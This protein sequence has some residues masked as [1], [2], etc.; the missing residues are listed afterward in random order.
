MNS[1]EY[2]EVAVR[3]DPFSE[4]LS[5]RVTAEVAELPYESFVTEEPFLKCYIQKDLY[6][7]QPLKAVLSGFPEVAEFT[8]S[9][10]QAQNWNASWESEFRPIVVD[11]KVTV[12]APF[13]TDVPRTRLNIW[14]DPKMAFGTAS[15]PTTYMMM[16]S[17]LSREDAIRGKLVLDMGCGTG[18]LGILAA[19]MG[20]A[21]VYA[22]DIDAV[23]AHSAWGNARWNRV[24]SRMEIRC[25]DA[26]LL[27]MGKYDVILANINRNILLQDLPTY[28]RSLRRG[29]LL[30]LSGFFDC[31]VPVLVKAAA[32]CGLSPDLPP[33]SGSLSSSSDLSPSSVDLSSFS[34]VIPDSFRNLLSRDGWACLAFCK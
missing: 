3:L 20:A 19:K 32:A 6:A 25:G 24:G 14:I 23:A 10:V 26:S 22:V 34:G 13:N 11:G 15:H 16:S 27:Q 5:E 31:D 21:K 1:F 8:A 12:K 30:L 28:A 29:G 9:L 7:P 18:L 17:M 4:E 2:I 33:S